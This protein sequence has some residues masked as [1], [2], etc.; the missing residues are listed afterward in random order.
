MKR[1][2]TRF[3]VHANVHLHLI[4]RWQDSG[5]TAFITHDGITKELELPETLFPVLALLAIAILAAQSKNKKR[6]ARGFV[7]LR[8]L[9][10]AIEAKTK[11]APQL[12]HLVRY[13]HR[14]R[15]M[16]ASLHSDP[17]QGSRWAHEI[18]QFRQTLGYRLAIPGKNLKLEIIDTGPEW[19]ERTLRECGP[20]PSSVPNTTRQ[21]ARQLNRTPRYRTH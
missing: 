14:L 10:V 18:L 15:K 12:E 1:R 20:P 9:Q 16:F 4:G 13:I 8:E 2:S 19:L 21:L 5:G 11:W 6:N 17:G 7:T 3:P